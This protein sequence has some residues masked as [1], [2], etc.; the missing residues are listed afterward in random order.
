MDLSDDEIIRTV[1]G[2]LRS[3]MGITEEP[4]VAKLY[5]WTKAN[6][7]YDVG[8]LDRVRLIEEGLAR[9]PGIYLAGAAYHG[10]GVPD[11]IRSG[12]RAAEGALAFLKP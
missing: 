2:D 1:R 5:R 9:H 7:Q 11:C 10:V 6:P 8:H 12:T 4:V 3:V